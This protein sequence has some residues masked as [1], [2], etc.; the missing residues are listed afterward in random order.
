MRTIKTLL[1]IVALSFSSVLMAST[2]AEDK[3]TE[4]D[5]IRVE[6]G[7]LLK[8]PSFAI[9]D[10]L[11][12]RVVFTLNNNKEIVVL[13]V[14]TDNYLVESYIKSRLNYKKINSTLLVSQEFYN[15]PVRLKPVK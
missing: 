5:V 4:S 12:A 1:L 10:E 13:S 15:I 11:V 9:S 8:N 3:R 7:K 6:I 2:N 14:D